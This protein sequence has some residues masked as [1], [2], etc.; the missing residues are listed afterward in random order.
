MRFYN[1][2]LE[3]VQN[4]HFGQKWQILKKKSFGARSAHLFHSQPNFLD[5]ASN[6]GI[7]SERN[8][9]Q[10]M[11]FFLTYPGNSCVISHSEYVFILGSV[12]WVFATFRNISKFMLNLHLELWFKQ[13]VPATDLSI[14]IDGKLDPTAWMFFNSSFLHSVFVRTPAASQA[15]TV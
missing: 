11:P 8:L 13:G 10:L 14:R 15:E 7:G 6:L 3:M 5:S 12:F 2:W 4:R 9:G 1:F